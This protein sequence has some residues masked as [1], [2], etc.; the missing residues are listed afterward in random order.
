MSWVA[1]IVLA[2]LTASLV[3]PIALADDV[4]DGGRQT[5]PVMDFGIARGGDKI[6]DAHFFVGGRESI[7]AGD[8][9]Y[10]D[11]GLLHDFRD[12]DWSFKL[13]GGY[14]F[15]SI[16]SFWSSRTFKRF[17]LDAL[18]IYSFDRQHIGFGVTYHF[19]PQLDMNGHGTDVRYHDVAGAILQYQYWLFGVRYTYIRYR[20]ETLPGTPSFDGSSLGL[21]ISI[22]FGKP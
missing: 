18:A 16:G 14:A 5:Y 1:R 10:G 15:A 9:V 11:V 8:A 22:A 6:L 19:N 4:P 13:T 17:P 2:A 12:S 3:P 7:H 21:F 20:P